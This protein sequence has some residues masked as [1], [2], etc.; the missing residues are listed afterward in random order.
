MHPVSKP[1]RSSSYTATFSGISAN[2]YYLI[3]YL[4]H[5]TINN[6]RL[7]NDKSFL[8]YLVNS[9]YL[10]VHHF[11]S[12]LSP[13]HPCFPDVLSFGIPISEIITHNNHKLI[14]LALTFASFF[15]EDLGFATLLSLLTSFFLEG[16]SF[17]ALLTTLP[18]SISFLNFSKSLLTVIF[19]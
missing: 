3:P 7:P 10:A 9:L 5:K 1:Y 13:R 2:L 16:F 11:S 17:G 8:K 6:L 14:H 15:A 19:L 18:S 4:R 12:K